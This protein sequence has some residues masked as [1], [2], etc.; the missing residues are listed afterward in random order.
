MKTPL[1]SICIPCF[2]RVEYVRRTLQ[3]IYEDNADADQSEFEVVISD[4]DPDE[5]LRP[6][7]E[8]LGYANLRYVATRCEGFMNSWHVLT[9]ACGKLLKLHN[10][11]VA[12]RRGALVAIISEARRFEDGRELIFFTNGFINEGRVAECPTFDDFWRIL[13]YW[14]SWSNGFSIWKQD[15]DALENINLNRL[16]PHTSVFVTQHSKQGYVA[17]DR[18]LFDTQRVKGRSG[19]NK[20]EAFTIEFPSIMAECHAAGGMSTGTYN[21]TL[22][23]IMTEFLPSLLFNK[24]VARIEDYDIAG[25]RRN[26]RRYFPAGAYWLSWACVALVPLRM[27]LRRYRV[28]ALRSMPPAD[29]RKTKRSP[30][31]SQPVI[32]GGVES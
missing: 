24:Y 2:K 9:Y 14:P 19:H 18:P 26:I 25:Y 7:V 17:D 4:N 6:L 11:Q 1:L 22:R 3:S 8:S 12:L 30:I 23:A 32:W 31:G 16:F 10:S 20:F 29:M 15:F 13:S 5:E 21:K 27:A 28:M